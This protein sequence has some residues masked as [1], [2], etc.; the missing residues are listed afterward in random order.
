MKIIISAGTFYPGVDVNNRY[1][2][3]QQKVTISNYV[4]T[5][6]AEKYVTSTQYLARGHLAAKTD[7][8]YAT[9]QRAT[10]YFIN[11]A[12]QWQQFNG[13]NWNLLEQNLR[14]RIGAAG[15]NTVVYT[16]TYGILQLRDS[17]NQL[18]SIYLHRDS[19][20][21]TQLPVPLYYYKVVYDQAKRLGTAFVGINNPYITLEEARSLQFCNDHCR[22]NSSFTWL[23]WQPDRVDRGYSFCCSI[24][25][26]RTFVPH[27]PSFTV[28]DLLTVGFT[29][30]NV[31]Y[32]LYWSCF[33]QNRLEV[34]YVWYEQNPP[35]AVNQVGVSRPSWR[36]GT[37]YPGVDVNNRYT[38]AQQK[39]TVSNY[40]GTDLAEKYV[41]STQ[42]LARG[43]LAAKTDFIYATGQR[44]TFYFINCA[45]QWQQFNGG[46]WNLLEQNLRIRIG[47]AGYNTV[48]YTGTYGILQLRDSNNQ[49]VDIYLHRDSNNNTQLPVPLYYYKVVYDQAKRLGTAFVGINNPYITLEEA[50]TLQFCNDHCRSNSSF[51]WLSWQPDR[52][53]RGY[54]FCCSIE[55]FRTFV[56]HLPSFT[57]NGLLT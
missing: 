16:G 44:A 15:Y 28:N 31:F 26:F 39:V 4:G 42:Y 34:L 40:V 24:E 7:F 32:P 52:V 29:V 2:V 21:N 55:D 51:T 57:V 23:S 6:L 46:N 8:I 1:T 50:R 27:L 14:I 38:V 37:F 22:S 36:A 49:L 12:P 19:N 5:D 33:D 54:S 41:T 20:N 17:N 48:V 10:F 45:P 13:G 9:G 56:P 18:S 30:N 35:N 43:H 47:A 53:D 25:D 11:C 3:A